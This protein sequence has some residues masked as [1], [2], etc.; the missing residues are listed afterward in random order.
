MGQAVTGQ[1]ETITPEKRQRNILMSNENMRYAYSSIKPVLHDKKCPQVSKIEDKHFRMREDFAYG[2]DHC[3][4]CYRRAILRSGLPAGQ[5]KQLNKYLQFFDL[6]G[7]Q[8]K[9]LLKLMIHNHAQ[10]CFART[11]AVGI[12]VKEDSWKIEYTKGKS[13]LYHNSYYFT[14]GY[15]RVMTGDYHLQ[16]T[17][18]SAEFSDMVKIM[19]SYSWK[20]HINKFEKE[21]AL[22]QLSGN[23][24]NT[25]NY[26]ERK[27]FS[28]FSC[29]FEFVDCDAQACGLLTRR[30]VRVSVLMAE[31][32]K[33]R[34]KLMLVKISR[35]DKK[36][37]F[38][39]MNELK[40]FAEKHKHTKYVSKCRRFCELREV[41]GA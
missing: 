2:W 5:S 34:Y 4:I 21:K 16:N 19:C 17:D 26:I 11:D 30:G 31:C 12:T 14:D 6:V 15:Q 8:D 37:F 39:A 18:K 27:R 3:P 23:L 28:P 10:L 41:L 38:E 32:T 9:D 36:K 33:E 22:A 1:N 35:R 40:E 25:Y 20:S 29:Y 13:L 24:A 7:A